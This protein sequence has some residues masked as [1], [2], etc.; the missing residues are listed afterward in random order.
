VANNSLYI[1]SVKSGLPL[2][3]TEMLTPRQQYNEYVM[4]SIRTSEGTDIA[5][6]LILAGPAHG[7]VLMNFRKVF[8]GNGWIEATDGRLQLTREGKL[9]ADHIA[10][11]MFIV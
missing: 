7:S 1:Q 11:E 8:L 10:S 4:T 2:V 9:F 5:R 3:E 6:A